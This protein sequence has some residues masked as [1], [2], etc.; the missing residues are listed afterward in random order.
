MQSIKILGSRRRRDAWSEADG[1]MRTVIALRK[2][3]P[4]MPKGVHRFRS[5]KEAHQ[6]AIKMM[7]RSAPQVPRHEEK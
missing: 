2:T 6:W 3:R 4:F 7:A 1:L 5:F